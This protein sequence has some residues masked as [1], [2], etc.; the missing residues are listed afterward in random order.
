MELPARHLFT[1]LR[2]VGVSVRLGR[3][4][5]EIL[6]WGL[7]EPFWWRNWLHTHSFY[8][9]CYA[10]AGQGIFR[11]QG[12]AHP[13][14]AGEVF[15]AR[16]GEE[17]EIISSEQEPLGIYFWSYTLVRGKPAAEASTAPGVQAIDRL[18]ERFIESTIPVSTRVPGMR[19]TLELLTEEI[20][21]QEPGCLS[22]IEALAGK[23][24]LDTARAVVQS[25]AGESVAPPVRNAS[26]AVAR[27]IQRYLQ[28][29]AARPITLR[30]VAAQVHLSERQAAR[31]F[32]REI[33]Q[34]VLQYLTHLRLQAAAQMLLRRD[35]PVKRI[36]AEVGYPDVHYFATLFRKHIGFTPGAFRDA[37]GTDF[38]DPALW[39]EGDKLKGT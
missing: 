21:R 11:V 17:H 22:V 3:Y 12:Q 20:V 37:G 26:E 30:D 38:R 31:V 2:R 8:E 34:T 36:A 29:N 7:I 9:I 19:Q 1:E 15:I 35:L 4:A 23:L 6:S 25:V 28:D 32:K 16:P 27:T 39:S 13:V 14:R 10:Y 24:L 18:L 5:G 33:G